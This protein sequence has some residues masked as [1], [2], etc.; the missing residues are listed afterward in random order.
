[1]RSC[2]PSCML[3]LGRE[4]LLLVSMRTFVCKHIQNAHTQ[5]RPCAYATLSAMIAARM[6]CTHDAQLSRSVRLYTHAGPH[7]PYGANPCCMSRMVKTQKSEPRGICTV[8]ATRSAGRACDIVSCH[9]VA[10]CIPLVPW[11]RV[12][13]Q[14]AT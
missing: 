7:W 4:A 8:G 1:M 3:Q 2:S 13:R 5:C 9:A 12:D 10:N 14:K 6:T 11:Q